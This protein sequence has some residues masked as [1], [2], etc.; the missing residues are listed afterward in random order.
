MPSLAQKLGWVPG[1][2][3][4]SRHGVSP[5]PHSSAEGP[6]SKSGSHA[7]R[8][9]EQHRKEGFVQPWG[10]SRNR[11]VKAD[12]GREQRWSFQEEGRAGTTAGSRTGRVAGAVC[13]AVVLA[14]H[15]NMSHGSGHLEG[16]AA[17][18]GGEGGLGSQ[19]RGLGRSP[20]GTG[21][22]LKE[23]S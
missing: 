5:G 7:L 16:V 8:E 9:A 2:Q 18:E 4:W 20:D 11:P 17:K 6:S 19:V 3:S 13:Q 22:P 1:T 14:Q 15:L 21:E 23:L 10:C 12:C